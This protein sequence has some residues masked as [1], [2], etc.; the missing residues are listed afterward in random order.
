MNKTMQAIG[1]VLV[2]AYSYIRFSTPAQAE[3]DSLR[4]QT[5][6]AAEWCE[7]NGVKLD[8]S[9]TFHDLGRSAFLGEHR[10]N[11]DRHALAAFLELVKAGRVPRGSFLV[12]EGLDRLTREHVRSGLMLLLGLIESGIRIVQLSPSE[13][14]YDDKSD[15]MSLMLAI[16]ELSRGHRESKRKS[17]MVGKAWQQKKKMARSEGRVM[18]NRLPAWVEMK[19]DKL[20]L[21]HSKAQAVR[22][23]FNLAVSGYGQLAIAKKLNSEGVPPIGDS[24][25]WQRSYIGLILS[26]RRAVGEFQPRKATGEPDGEPIAGYYPSVVT[27]K[28]FW[29]V[30]A[31]AAQRR[32]KP[33]R[34]STHRVNVFSGLLRHSR[35][36]D[37]FMLNCRC[38]RSDRKASLVLI[39]NRSAEGST[40]C[41]SFPFLPFER[42]L[43]QKLAEIDPKEVLGQSEGADEVLALSGELAS[44]EGMI[45]ELEHELEAGV[46]VAAVV[47]V[48]RKKEE[49][50]R[51]LLDALA[52]AKQQAANPLSEAWGE[53]VS[54][55][56]VIDQAA[57]QDD[58]R[59]RLRSVLR[60]VV[61][62]IWC[63]FIRDG[64]TR[65]AAVQIYFVGGGRRELFIYFRPPVAGRTRNGD[66]WA[67]EGETRVISARDFPETEFDL[68]NPAVAQVVEKTLLAWRKDKA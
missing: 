55:A 52:S 59:I 58:A 17:D 11:P 49:R 23:I 16:V 29:N 9:T 25:K 33:G 42:S 44:V 38:A 4:R 20:T 41:H 43:L 57:D 63:L 47:R 8:T 32:D 40:T 21:I 48:L 30:R 50:K 31:G 18:T 64:R 10:K 60:R 68:R 65:L 53:C 34:T 24:A 45:A 19:D 66:A 61:S 26:D 62:E 37:T 28:K 46:E 14:I 1:S 35:D 12:I 13:V 6:G 7:R 27:E 5:E 54:L 39:N 51:E 2:L 56:S 67:V 36:G 15:E 3:G 22:T